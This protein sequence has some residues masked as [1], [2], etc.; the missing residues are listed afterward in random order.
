MSYTITVSELKA[1]MDKGDKIFLLDVREPHEYSLAKIEG[2]VLIPLGQ[3]P[4]SLKQL[5][6]SAEIVAYCHKGMRSADAV[7]FLLQ[8]G[9]SNVKNLIGGIEAWSIEIDQSVPRY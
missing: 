6:P 8:Q 9:F 4:H 3:V 1:R 7:G 5:D 2:S